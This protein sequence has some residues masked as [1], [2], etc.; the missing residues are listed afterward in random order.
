MSSTGNS[1]NS[2]FGRTA[3]RISDQVREAAS[4]TADSA[5]RAGQEM[6]AV[7]RT[8]FNNVL[9][10]LQ[11]LAARAGKVSGRE[12]GALRDQMS[13][14]LVVAKKKLGSLT[15][16][17]TVAARKSVDAT[18]DVIKGRPFQSVAVAVLA[19]FAIG[20]LLGRRGDFR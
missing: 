10:D 1:T 3:E 15:D 5:R 7:A 18:G 20:L 9:S 8:E 14:K 4:S 16:D 2:S 13:E 17:A 11:D 19:G 12:L 6:G